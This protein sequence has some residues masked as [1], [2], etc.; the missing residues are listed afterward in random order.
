MVARLRCGILKLCVETGRYT[1][2]RLEDR[3]CTICDM[4]VIEDE[5]HFIC[6]CPVYNDQRNNFYRILSGIDP[7][8]DNLIGRGEIFTYIVQNVSKDTAKFIIQIWNMRNNIIY[9]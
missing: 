9:V 7:H 4:G 8:F 2:I 5:V 3:I 1:N 6:E